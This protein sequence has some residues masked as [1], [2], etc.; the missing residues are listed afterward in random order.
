MYG[1]LLGRVEQITF[2]ILS[3]RAFDIFE[4]IIVGHFFIE[5]NGVRYIIYSSRQLLS[6]CD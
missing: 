5:F 1:L 4:N 2:Q 6:S 3:C